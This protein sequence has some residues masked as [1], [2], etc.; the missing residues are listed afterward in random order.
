MI[1]GGYPPLPPLPTNQPNQYAYRCSP[2]PHWS[3]LS[4]DVVKWSNYDVPFPAG[5]ECRYNTS[6]STLEEAHL[7]C[8]VASRAERTPMIHRKGRRPAGRGGARDRQWERLRIPTSQELFATANCP[9]RSTLV[10]TLPS[11][12]DS[13]KS[14]RWFAYWPQSSKINIR[15]PLQQ[16]R[17]RA[18]PNDWKSLSLTPFGKSL[19]V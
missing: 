4:P 11:C 5:V 12:I 19:E 10:S 18:V 6:S 3:S 1:A 2:D 14:T 16:S 9:R 13:G 15:R 7:P 17:W 8:T